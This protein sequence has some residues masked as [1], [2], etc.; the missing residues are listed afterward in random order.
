M[1]YPSKYKHLLGIYAVVTKVT[2][3]PKMIHMFVT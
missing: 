2:L 1:I 3:R